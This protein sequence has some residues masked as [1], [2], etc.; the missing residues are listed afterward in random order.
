[1]DAHAALVTAVKTLSVLNTELQS[2]V[3]FVPKPAQAPV[4]HREPPINMRL[5]AT[6]NQS[7]T[8]YPKATPAPPNTQ[9]PPNR[10]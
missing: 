9:N 4:P 8:P 6:H 10:P 2:A 5:D 1:V 7:E 3:P